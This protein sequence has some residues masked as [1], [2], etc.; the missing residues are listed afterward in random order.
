MDTPNGLFQRQRRLDFWTW[1]SRLEYT[2]SWGKL[3]FSSQYKLMLLR[4]IDQERDTRLRSEMRSIP[5]LRAEY[6]LLPR[7]R[8][9][10]GMQGVGSFPYRH[11]NHISDHKSFDRHTAFVTVTNLSSYFGYELVTIA[12]VRK[13]HRDFETRFQDNRDFDFLSFFIRGMIGFTEF[14]RPI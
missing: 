7:T 4:L 5:I 6:A 13:D 1:V 14:G 9:K 2:H 3:R 8:L 10:V 11:R 12:G